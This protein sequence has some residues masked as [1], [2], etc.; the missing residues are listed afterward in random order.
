MRLCMD[1]PSSSGSAS[2]L[3]LEL[4]PEFLYKLIQVVSQSIFKS[5]NISCCREARLAGSV[6]A[7]IW[8][9]L[10]Y[11]LYFFCQKM[12][13]KMGPGQ[14]GTRLEWGFSGVEWV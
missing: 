2:L 9:Y 7:N 14:S 3:L 6:L 4:T 12:K 11:H 10:F 13:G 5:C 1:I 8:I